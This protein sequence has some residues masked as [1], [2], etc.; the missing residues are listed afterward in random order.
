[1][2]ERHEIIGM[3]TQ[4]QARRQL[5]LQE[6]HLS[7]PPSQKQTIYAR[8]SKPWSPIERRSRSPFAHRLTLKLL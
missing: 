5:A 8:A 4:T 3:M 2:M 6:L 1:M 7:R